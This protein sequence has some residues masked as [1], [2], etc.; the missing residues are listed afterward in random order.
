MIQESYRFVGIFIKFCT[1]FHQENYHDYIVS[2]VRNK[3]VIRKEWNRKTILFTVYTFSGANEKKT[4]NMRLVKNVKLL[5]AHLKK[6]KSF[7]WTQ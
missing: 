4:G 7:K 2:Q 5:N 1:G 6:K 3:L